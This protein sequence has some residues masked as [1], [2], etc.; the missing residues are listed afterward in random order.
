M[1]KLGILAST[2]ATD[3]QAVI[4]EI[5]DGTLDAEIAVLVANKE[6]CGALE[7]AR[8]HNIPAC[9]ISSKN[10]SMEEFDREADKIL[11]EK[12]VE[13]VLLIGYMK[14]MSPWF[15]REWKHKV[16]NIHPS[17]LPKFA[18]GMD[19]DVHQAVLDAGE[20]VTGATLHFV[21]EEVDAGPIILQR[22]VYV[23]EEDTADSLKKKVQAAEQEIILKAIRL[24]NEGKIRVEDNR[25]II[26][27]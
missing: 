15:V 14:I 12:G 20:K 23:D 26:S 4:D 24:F 21:A 18:G 7:R 6:K 13:L 19:L 17:L 16:V 1:I 5:E 10:K 2:N 27:E 9:Y 8:R 22:E 25:V 3:M 11:K